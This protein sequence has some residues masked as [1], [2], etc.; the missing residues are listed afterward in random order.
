MGKCAII[1]DEMIAKG[2]VSLNASVTERAYAKINLTLDVTGRRDNGY[3]DVVSVMQRISLFD[4]LYAVR[5]GT[6][7]V[8]ENDAGLPCDERNL[9]MRAVRAYF[10]ETG[11]PF[12]V[13]L[14][15]HKQIPMQAGLGGGSADAAAAL[16]AL[17]AL[18]GYPLSTGALCKIGATLGAD[19]PFCVAERT[20]ICRGIGEKMTP[21]ANRLAGYL[22]IAMLGEGV[23]TPWAFGALDA[24]YADFSDILADAERRLPQLSAALER[25]DL[26]AAAAACYNRFSDVIEPE[27]PAVVTVRETMLRTGAL[28]ACM[29]G[30]G[31][32]VFGIF[33]TAGAAEL[34]ASEL[35]AMR[36]QAFVCQFGA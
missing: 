9:V 32:S 31:P 19:V 21:I 4:T 14:T 25:G 24:R 3:H 29:S 11:Y 10:A 18:D 12:G 16:R 13:H 6:D 36:A 33:D 34:A 7:A 28:G 27:R 5:V 35:R 15:L 2:G 17:N 8:L 22:V 1:L 20:A 30:T 26:A 23:S